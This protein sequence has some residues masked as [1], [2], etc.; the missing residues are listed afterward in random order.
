MFMNIEEVLSQKPYGVIYCLTCKVNGKVYIGATTDF[1]KRMYDYDKLRCKGQIKIYRAIKKYGWENF[2]YD[3]IDMT[4]SQEI[5]DFLEDFYM[6]TIGSRKD[7]IGYNTR[8]GGSNGKHSGETKN[9]ISNSKTGHSVSAETKN[10]ISETL[11]KKGMS[12][13]TK[14]NTFRSKK[15]R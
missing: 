14:K 5:L 9:K 1:W 10:K 8:M 4:I 6:E 13:E 12:D 11:K 15:K 3:I 2:S 7:E